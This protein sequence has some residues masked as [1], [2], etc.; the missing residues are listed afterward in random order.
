MQP[1]DFAPVLRVARVMAGYHGP[2]WLTGGWAIDLFAGRLTRP[3]ADLEIGILRQDQQHLRVHLEGWELCQA[4]KTRSGKGSWQPWPEGKWLDQPIHQIRARRPEAELPEFEAFLNQ[5]DGEEWE[6]RR[7]EGLTRPLA[8]VCLPSPLGVPVL[9]P[10]I[11]LLYKAKYHRQKDDQD[12]A[13]L[14]PLLSSTQRA[15][16]RSVLEEYHPHDPWLAQL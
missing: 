11:Q 1:D 15:W 14:L 4:V 16:L 3:H 10:E 13:A 6:S 5:G 8:E 9:A 12:F 7:H 2:W